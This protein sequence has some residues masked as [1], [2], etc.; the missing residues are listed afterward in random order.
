[1]DPEIMD[2]PPDGTLDDL[3]GTC[4]GDED[5]LRGPLVRFARVQDA[6]GNKAIRAT[7]VPIPLNQPYVKKELFFFDITTATPA[8]QHAIEVEQLQAGH[9]RIPEAKDVYL[10][11]TEAQVAVYREQ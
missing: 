10:A 11:N 1:M 4:G 9:A 2:Y 8:Q 6:E 3:S 7:Y 5:G